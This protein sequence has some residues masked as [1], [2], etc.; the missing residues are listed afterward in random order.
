MWS[1]LDYLKKENITSTPQF[2]GKWPFVRIF[3]IQEPISAFASLLHIFAVLYMFKRLRNEID[4]R[5]DLKYLWYGSALF[6]LNAW[7]W[8]TIFH[9]KDTEFTE[10]MD[11][12][13]A[14]ALVLYQFN[15]FFV[16][17]FAYNHKKKLIHIAYFLCTASISYFAYHVYYL[18]FVHF[19]YNYN[20]KVNIFV[21]LLNSV[22]WLA[23]STRAYRNREYSRNCLKATMLVVFL[24][25]FE[26]LEIEPLLWLADSH[27]LWHVTTLSVHFYLFPF[28]I[29]DCNYHTAYGFD[30]L[31]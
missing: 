13:S 20:M 29:D 31:E 8:S 17:Y 16:R 19:D 5:A 21:G 10:H 7:I 24:T 6:N 22:C 15:S 11:Y 3:G 2:Y 12:F 26:I 14:F 30:H 4:S 1:T 28:Y 23:W 25:G 27:A 18:T 9:S